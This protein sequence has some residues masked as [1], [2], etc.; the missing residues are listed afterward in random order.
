V[1]R[2]LDSSATWERSC[3]AK[4]DD[5]G[6]DKGADPSWPTSLSSAPCSGRRMRAA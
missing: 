5:K 3:S 2:R 6:D 1:P 4:G